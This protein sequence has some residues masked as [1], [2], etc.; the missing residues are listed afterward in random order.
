MDGSTWRRYR[1]VT[2]RGEEPP[3]F[4]EPDNPD[5]YPLHFAAAGFAPLAAYSSAVIEPLNGEDPRVAE[6]ARRLAQ[7]GVIIRN[8]DPTCFRE[9]LRRVYEVSVR[10]FADNFLYTPIGEKEF[11]SQYAGLQRVLRPELVFLAEE[12]GALVGFAFVTPDFSQ[13]ARGQPIDTMILKTLARVPGKRYAG[14]GAVLT[15]RS[16]AAARGLGFRRAIHALMHDQNPSQKLNRDRA[17]TIRRY[18]LYARRL[19]G[20]IAGG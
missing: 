12:A 7:A 13:A 10:A 19:G 3:F 20:K 18:T 6:A 9:E 4:L 11:L 16:H 8:F 2:D 17:R 1:L 14:L 5:D 15:A